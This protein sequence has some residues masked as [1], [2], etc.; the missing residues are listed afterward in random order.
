MAQ[1]RQRLLFL[2]STT[3]STLADLLIAPP[4]VTHR[5]GTC[6]CQHVPPAKTVDEA[7]KSLP[8]RSSGEGREVTVRGGQPLFNHVAMN[9]SGKV[10]VR[11]KA[12][13]PGGGKI[14]YRRLELRE[15]GRTIIA[16]HRAL[17]VHPRQHRTITVREA[18]RLQGF[19]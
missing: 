7:L 15:P 8:A 5:V 14:S 1:R 2:A 18:A 3:S 9:H 19:E 12:I 16:G 17:P 6:E 11:I 4:A 10:I 13:V